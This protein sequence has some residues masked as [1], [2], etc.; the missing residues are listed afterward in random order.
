MCT[1]GLGQFPT[2]YSI[3][4]RVEAT[5]V[6]PLVVAE[7]TMLCWI[8]RR[9]PVETGT[10]EVSV[11]KERLKAMNAELQETKTELQGTK[12]ELQGTKMELQG[13]KTELHQLTE[14]LN[15]LVKRDSYRNVTSRKDCLTRASRFKHTF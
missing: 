13:R 11:L 6:A 2:S 1:P 15:S 14:S 7:C 8:V 4:T 12:S 9:A 5:A 10:D 3:C